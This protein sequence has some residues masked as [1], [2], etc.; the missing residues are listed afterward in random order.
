[1]QQAT[2]SKLGFIA[3]TLSLLMVF[4]AS[5]TPIP[6]YDIYR[7][8][9]GLS[10]S[11]L[12]MTAVVYFFGAVTALLFFGRISNHIGRKPV[13]FIVFGL[14]ITASLILLNVTSAAPL[15]LGR[16]LLGLACGLASSG[17]A[18]YVVDHAPASYEW[19]PSAVVSNSP[20]VGLTIGAFASGSLVEYGP[21]PKYLCYLVILAV[22]VVCAV[23]VALSKETVKKQ[24]GLVSSLRPNFALPHRDKRLYPIAAC[25]FI[26]TWALGGF[27]QAFA[28]SIAA[29]Q[30]G[31]QSTLV[32]ALIF[33]SYL[34]PGAFAAPLVSY[35]TPVNAQRIGM[36]IFTVAVM[37][38]LFSLK[39][40]LL[41]PFIL[42]SVLAG[43]A[44]GMVLTG[45]TRSLLNN[46]SPKERAGVLSLIFT[47]SYTGAAISTLVVGQLSHVMNLFELA[48][49]YGALAIL[50]CSI[51]LL[52][53]R[54]PATDSQ[55]IDTSYEHSL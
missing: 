39:A 48:C 23:L 53:A 32:A 3:A 14:A 9:D 11:D 40:S 38:I 4:A 13:A 7:V 55:L 49:C 28:P 20:M 42:F 19:L 24:T 15:I 46:I 52:F 36:I 51:T 30:L 5:A 37:G 10:Y 8:E 17:I 21:Y 6:L 2:H 34:I 44:Q 26:S 22:I 27:F 31:H 41:I 29:T 45:S 1:M 50:G 18:S 47:T 43:A 33:S 54:S 16:L 12:S 35:I 25:T